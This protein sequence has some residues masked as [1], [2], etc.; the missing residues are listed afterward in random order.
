MSTAMGMFVGRSTLFHINNSARK[1][2]IYEI[3]MRMKGSLVC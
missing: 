3:V 2:K 1:R